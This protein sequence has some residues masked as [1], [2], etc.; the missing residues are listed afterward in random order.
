MNFKLQKQGN[1]NQQHI[2]GYANATMFVFNQMINLLD[3]SG[4][5]AQGRLDGGQCGVDAGNTIFLPSLPTCL[6]SLGG[7]GAGR[8]GRILSPGFSFTSAPGLPTRDAGVQFSTVIRFLPEA[9]IL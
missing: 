9:T 3:W 6:S 4:T 7:R 5:T 1:D 2:L 8:V